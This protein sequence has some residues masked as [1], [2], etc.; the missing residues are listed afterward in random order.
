MAPPIS[1]QLYSLR[2][3]AA[4]GFEAVLRRLGSAGFVGVEPAGLHGMTPE[5]FRS[6][7]ADAGL[8]V[9]SA[10]TDLAIGTNAD[11]VLDE[12]EAIGNSFIM[13]SGRPDDFADRGAIEALASRFNEAAANAAARGVAVG[14]HN[15]WW[16]F[17]RQVDGAVAYDLFCSLL[18]PSVFLE[19]D[20][21]WVQVG[22]HDPA[23]VIAA[24]GERARFLHVKDGQLDP[25]K[26]MTAA[27][28]GKVD[29]AAALSAGQHVEWHVVELDECG[30]DMFEAVEKSRRYLV[31]HGL[32]SGR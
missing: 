27:G 28:E 3:E 24:A 12:Q 14:Y 16:E 17:D 29:L 10:H 30:T 18:D 4:A 9:S 8:V 32:S 6:V 25:P 21:Y 26:P 2:T 22:G 7:V 11:A 31:G 15:H 23:S 13:S 1:V 19:I 20:I 5:R